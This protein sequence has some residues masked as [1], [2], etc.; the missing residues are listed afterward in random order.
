MRIIKI[1]GLTQ[2]EFV[3]PLEWAFVLRFSPRSRMAQELTF[4]Y[5]REA[6]ILYINTVDPYAEQQSEELGDEVV[7]RLNPRSGKIQNLEA[8]FFSGRLLRRE[9][10]SLPVVADLQHAE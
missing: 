2:E 1:A 8:L 7:A 3:S 4:Q 9:L 6:A 5:H 10:L